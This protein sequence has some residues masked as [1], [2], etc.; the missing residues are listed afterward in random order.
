MIDAVNATHEALKGR[1]LTRRRNVVPR[2]IRPEDT[3]IKFTSG[4][5]SSNAFD[6][7]LVDSYGHLKHREGGAYKLELKPGDGFIDSFMNHSR[8][9]LQYANM[10]IPARN[11][12][13]L[14]N[15]PDAKEAIQKRFGIQ[16]Y[17]GFEDAI[18]MQVAGTPQVS[19]SEKTI[20]L[21][22][23][24][25]AGAH[26]TGKLTV[27]GAQ[28]LDP[29]YAAAYDSGG[30]KHYAAGMHEL[31]GRRPV[32]AIK[33]M[34]AVLTK[35][36]GEYWL[37]NLSDDVATVQT[38]GMYQRGGHFR[39]PTMSQQMIKATVQLPEQVLAQLPNYMA[40]KAEARERFGL[41]PTDQKTYIDDATWGRAIAES[42]TRKTLR[43]STSS[44]P[45]ELSGA[46]RFARKNPLAG[47][48]MN[49]LNQTKNIASVMQVG[50]TAA[51][52]G[53]Y[54]R[55]ATMFGTTVGLGF[56]YAAWK[57]SLS[58]RRRDDDET[59]AGSVAIGMIDNLIT[60]IPVIGDL[61]D[62]AVVRPLTDRRV[63]DNNPLLLLSVASD[64]LTGVART[65]RNI[66]DWA[67]GQPNQRDTV[68]DLEDAAKLTTLLGL[69]VPAAL[70]LSKRL[71]NGDILPGLS[72]SESKPK[73]RKR[74]GRLRTTL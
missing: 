35:Y 31:A 44:H 41:D 12:E 54:G 53:H 55:A 74:S 7:V 66:Y 9:M 65:S 67:A 69:P 34:D 30:L 70:D 43:G 48:A 49:F 63:F 61:V 13:M 3:Y 42:W 1:P 64:G 36:S 4:D 19:G 20:R 14:L 57:E 39:V 45:L 33:E 40:A 28:A 23:S 17:K 6:T 37:R 16:G 29:L 25:V 50:V 73:K 47:L 71:Y 62:S 60:T 38:Y 22:N 32:D 24:A 72:R 51:R 46:L 59:F 52:Q 15:H 21:Y 18:R 56:L 68:R 5:R 11:A 58:L 8:R 2:H 10:A 27:A 26:I